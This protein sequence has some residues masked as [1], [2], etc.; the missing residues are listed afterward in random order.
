MLEP[1]TVRQ[2]FMLQAQK[3]VATPRFKRHNGFDVGIVTG[4]LRQLR[5]EAEDYH[6]EYYELNG[7]APYCRAVIAEMQKFRKQ[8]EPL[9]RV[10]WSLDSALLIN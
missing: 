9:L 7:E 4:S 2:F 10:Q 8:F 3:A 1:S 6:Q 5:F